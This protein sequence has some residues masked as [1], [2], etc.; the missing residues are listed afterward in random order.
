M[1][2]T[3]AQFIKDQWTTV[4]P[5]ATEDLSGKTIVVTGANVGLGFEAAKHFARMNPGK[6]ILACRSREK[7]EK[8]LA[9]TQLLS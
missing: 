1:R 6:L 4:P 8:A 9:G 7:G 2:L 3:V 5:L